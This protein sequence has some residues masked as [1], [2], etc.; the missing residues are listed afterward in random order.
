MFEGVSEN[1][2]RMGVREPR[3]HV[4]YGCKR[5]AVSPEKLCYPKKTHGHVYHIDFGLCDRSRDLLRICCPL[6]L[7]LGNGAGESSILRSLVIPSTV[8]TVGE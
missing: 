3:Y 1:S 5:P 4:L 6:T 2:T 8:I 7:A